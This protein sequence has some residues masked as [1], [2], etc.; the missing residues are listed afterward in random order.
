MTIAL[1][2]TTT[3][4][5]LAERVGWSER[6]VRERARELGA[7]RILGNRMIFLPEDVAAM[8]AAGPG[9][10]DVGQSIVY[11]IAVRGFIKIGWTR[12]WSNRLS[13]LQCA[14]PEP[15]EVLALLARPPVYERTMHEQFAAF[16]AR[17]EWF[18]DCKEIR[19]HLAGLKDELLLP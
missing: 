5:E 17:G 1:P 13:N 9:E 2:I 3:P 16:R 19:D 8:E 14:N 10:G 6:R 18:R 4:E 11:F 12:E 15:I 7:C